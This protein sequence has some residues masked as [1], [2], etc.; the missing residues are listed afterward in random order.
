MATPPSSIQNTIN[1]WAPPIIGGPLSVYAGAA[2][3]NASTFHSNAPNTPIS[4]ITQ[5]VRAQGLLYGASSAAKAA[6]LQYGLLG[7]LYHA[8]LKKSE[9]KEVAVGVTCLGT[10]L[11]TYVPQTKQVQVVG[12]HGQHSM[13]K[14]FSFS[15]KDTVRWVGISLT[16]PGALSF[17][18]RNVATLI[19]LRYATEP[20]TQFW[21]KH[22]PAAISKEHPHIIT[23]LGQ[24]SG[25]FGGGVLSALPNSSHQQISVQAVKKPN[26]P[27][28]LIS[29]LN[30]RFMTTQIG[31]RILYNTFVFG[32][33]GSTEK[34]I[35][36]LTNK[37]SQA[38]S[39]QD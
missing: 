21:T 16:G 33:F 15:P 26:T 23:V 36:A 7:P 9:S 17:A 4:I 32:T 10:Q 28:S 1:T 39:H 38:L 34:L 18:G 14:R 25:N 11:V 19:G 5:K 30:P 22:L 35:H 6:P 31:L 24:Y 13:P 20:C 37:T 3:K 29:H 12:T 27:Y 2:V 8:V